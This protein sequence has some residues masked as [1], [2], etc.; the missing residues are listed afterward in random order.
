MTGRLSVE[1]SYIS[2]DERGKK[3]HDAG[4]SKLGALEGTGSWLRKFTKI[5]GF[6]GTEHNVIEEVEEDHRVMVEEFRED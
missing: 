3:L 4:Q 2:K 6:L 5:D 1:C